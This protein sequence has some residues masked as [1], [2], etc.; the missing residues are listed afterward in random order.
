M[1]AMLEF[2]AQGPPPWVDWIVFIGL[3]FFSLYRF[4]G[5]F[6]HTAAGWM[7]MTAVRGEIADSVR[8]WLKSERRAVYH[9]Y[10]K[11]DRIFIKDLAGHVDRDIA[12][13]MDD[14]YRIKYQKHKLEWPMAYLLDR[15]LRGRIGY[16]HGGGLRKQSSIHKAWGEHRLAV[17]G[18]W[19]EDQRLPEWVITRE[20]KTQFVL[21]SAQYDLL[22]NKTSQDRYFILDHYMAEPRPLPYHVVMSADTTLQPGT[23]EARRYQYALH[24]W[25]EY[26]QEIQQ[27]A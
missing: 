15:I 1:R 8:E 18:K 26:Q 10:W 9:V 7:E 12:Y 19:T 14:A 13:E 5:L 27:R 6:L 22:T 3:M 11:N 16:L 25:E 17:E 4:Y 23:I 24:L 20:H 21:V 2:L